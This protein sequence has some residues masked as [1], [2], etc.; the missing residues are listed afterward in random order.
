MAQLPV[1]KRFSTEDFPGQK[2]WIGTLF[3]PLNLILTT[4]YSALNNGLT[5]S[6]NLQAQTVALSVAGSSPSVSFPYK[7]SPAIPL[8][9][10][11]VSVVQTNTPAVNLTAAVGC[12]WT[13]SSGVVTV[14]CQGLDASST[15]NVTFVVWGG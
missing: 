8:G 13:Y 9:V 5:I 10:S 14:T 2:D 4:L 7:Y 1:I 15:Y 6:Q 11:V 3:Y 12:L